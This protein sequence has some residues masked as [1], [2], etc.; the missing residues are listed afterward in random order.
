LIAGIATASHDIIPNKL[1]SKLGVAVATSAVRPPDTL[2]GIRRG[3]FIGT[4][5]NA[6]LKYQLTYLMTVG[7]HGGYMARGGFYDGNERVTSNPWAVFTTY[8][9]YGF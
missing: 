6:E 5:V 1:N 8:T 4:E 2:T 9:W 7:L 3:R